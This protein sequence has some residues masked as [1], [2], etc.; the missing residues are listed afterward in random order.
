[1]EL[2]NAIVIITGAATRVGRHVALDLAKHGAHIAFSYYLDEEPWQQ[3]QMEIQAFGVNA[4]AK[5][6]EVR[7]KDQVDAFV[8][9]V[10]HW[11]GR[12]D[13][14]INNASVWLKSP[15][16]EITEAEWDMS[17]DINLKGPFLCSQAVAPFMLQQERG[18][19]I[20]ITDISG[21]Q[22]WPE[23]THHAA[24]KAGLIS[25]TK[26]MAVELAP[27]IRVNAIAPGTVLLQENSTQEKINWAVNNS[28]VKR[29]G[30]PA[31]VAHLI[32]FLIENEFATGGIYPID[33]G[34]CLV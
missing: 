2:Q 27:H 14:L 34:R 19:I 4:M 9:E 16:L 30:E 32:R 20:N 17:L 25:L 12:I 21:L 15:F 33:G 26:S 18:V 31:H 5:K 11:F 3:T 7:S 6:V 23:C 8:Q 1:M 22:V 29:I 13:V 10:V 28:L 24:S